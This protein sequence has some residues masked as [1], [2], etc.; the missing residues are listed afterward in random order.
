MKDIG[1][2][3]KK[4]RIEAGLT[5]QKLANKLNLSKSSIASYENGS[6]RPSNKV[7]INISKLFNVSTDYLLG[8]SENKSK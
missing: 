1:N 6:R 4:E 7:L 8:I 5:Q 3:I 2:K